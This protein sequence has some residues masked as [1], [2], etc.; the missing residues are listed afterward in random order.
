MSPVHNQY[1]I[2]ESKVNKEDSSETLFIHACGQFEAAI[3]TVKPSKDTIMNKTEG[4][5]AAGQQTL[6]LTFVVKLEMFSSC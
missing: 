1:I 6:L 5:K 4:V 2:S 3:H